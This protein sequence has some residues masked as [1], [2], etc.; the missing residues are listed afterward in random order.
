MQAWL[1][2][3]GQGVLADLLEHFSAS[4]AKW[5]WGTLRACCKVASTVLQ[6]IRPHF[7]DMFRDLFAK[8]GEDK[9]IRATMCQVF[10][11]DSWWKR[12]R[13]IDIMASKTNRARTWA[14]GCPCHETQLMAGQ[15]VKCPRKGRRLKEARCFVKHVALQDL[16]ATRC[17][18]FPV[19]F[20]GSSAR[21][22]LQEEGGGGRMGEGKGDDDDD[23]VRTLTDV[24]PA[25]AADDD[26]DEDEEGDECHWKGD[27]DEEEESNVV[28]EEEGIANCDGWARDKQGQP[29]QQRRSAGRKWGG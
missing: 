1:R 11:D 21:L 29:A 16:Q 8:G 10:K 22:R 13:L 7:E 18:L 12:L 14:S 26:D 25:A 24:S 28:E 4:F 5:R 6:S 23:G 9:D 20:E 2:K 27:D 17:R 19:D 15:Y 3:R